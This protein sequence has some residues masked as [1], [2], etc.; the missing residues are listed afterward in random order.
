MRPRGACS[1][2]TALNWRITFQS[3]LSV[4]GGFR[5]RG[6]GA[7]WPRPDTNGH[8]DASELQSRSYV[9]KQWKVLLFINR[10]LALSHR[11]HR[12]FLT[13]PAAHRPKR[14]VPFAPATHT[15]D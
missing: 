4:L 5:R 8:K 7:S 10:S 1:R 13:N 9:A 3:C 15:W 6:K 11:T 14:F 12:L 2:D